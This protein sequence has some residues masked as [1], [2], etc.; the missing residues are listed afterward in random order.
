MFSR[1]ERIKTEIIIIIVKITGIS[2]VAEMCL[3]IRKKYTVRKIIDLINT[4]FLK[5]AIIERECFKR[6]K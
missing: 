3:D 1:P 2:V 5:T 6:L 4:M